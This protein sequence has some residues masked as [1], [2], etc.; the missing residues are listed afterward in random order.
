[1][2]IRDA[3]RNFITDVATDLF[4]NKSIN[5]VTVR[6]VAKAAG[7]GE[8]TVYRYF[9]R[10]QNMVIAVAESLQRKAYT[11]YFRPRRDGNGYSKIRAFYENYVGVLT[12]SP[13]FYKFVSEFDAY[14]ISEGSGPLEEY[15]AGVELFKDIFFAAYKEGL[16]DGS[17]R[18]LDDPETF[19]FSTAHAML[20][21]GKKFSTA[22]KIVKQDE[23][24][25]K[26][27]EMNALKDVVLFYIA[28]PR[29]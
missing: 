7:V 14:V 5:E 11:E 28:K 6:D 4:L 12:N 16:K 15:S 2:T 25:D 17:V 8:A 9:E 21:L 3:K 23:T 1:M 19:Y 22:G 13:E 29:A 27:A 10:K 26:V 18:E 24:T 20:E